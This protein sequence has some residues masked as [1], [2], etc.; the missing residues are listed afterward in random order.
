MAPKAGKRLHQLAREERRAQRRRIGWRYIPATAVYVVV[1][2]LG[3][4]YLA[5]FTEPPFVWFFA[6]LATGVSTL[7]LWIAA[8][9]ISAERL[10][11]AGFAEQWTSSEVRKLRHDG[12]RV[13]D[14]IPFE[15]SD[16]LAVFVDARHRHIARAR[17]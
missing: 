8:N 2:S 7:F 13:I 11:A 6:G 15:H 17:A 4:V 5:V 3:I 14:N 1:C 10:E 9:T 16:V 12:W